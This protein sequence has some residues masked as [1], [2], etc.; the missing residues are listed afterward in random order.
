MCGVRAISGGVGG[1]LRTKTAA[2]AADDI[3]GT[4]T[5]IAAGRPGTAAPGR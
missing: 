4:A 2:S 5:E 1:G 3:G